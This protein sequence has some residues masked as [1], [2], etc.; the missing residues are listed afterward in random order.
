MKKIAYLITNNAKLK[1]NIEYIGVID[2]TAKIAPNTPILYVGLENA[3][4]HI[5]NFSILDRNPSNNVFW[6]FG[7][8]EK[9]NEYEKDIKKFYD[10][11]LNNVLS[12]IKYYYI[13]PLTL[14]RIKLFKIFHLI[15]DK[16]FDKYFYFKNGMIYCY[17]DNKVL[18]FSVQIYEYIYK[19]DKKRIFEIL[20]KNPYNHIQDKNDN[21]LKKIENK[22]PKNKTYILSFFMSLK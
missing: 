9:R 8:R 7:K 16:R 2:D 14:N 5:P 1:T 17:F 13:N 3:R 15:Y 19:M 6:T 22:I 21:I 18:G 4:L 12:N 11:A 10:Y 20:K